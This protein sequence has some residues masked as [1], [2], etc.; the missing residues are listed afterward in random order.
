VKR[1]APLRRGK[2]LERS[3]PL[4]GGAPPARRTPLRAR[5]K[6]QEA[7]YRV[8]RPLVAELLAE[9]PVCQRCQA[10]RSTDVHEPRMRSRG[11]DINDPR[12][13]VALCRDCHNHVHAHP[14]EATREG[15]LVPSWEDMAECGVHPVSAACPE[16]TA[17][18]RCGPCGCE[19]AAGWQQ[20]TPA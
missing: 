8:R 2:P 3:T 11:A 20:R 13:C 18:K 14:A 17:C 16:C 7:L 19:L 15:W 1:S 6:K 10:A 4:Q 9:R 5:S 12:E